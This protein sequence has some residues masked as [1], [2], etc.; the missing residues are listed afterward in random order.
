[1]GEEKEKSFKNK[2]ELINAAITEF[3]EKGYEQA[4]LNN[5]LKEA[6][7]SKGTFYYHFKHK[8]EL[9]FYLVDIFIAEKKIFFTENIDPKKYQKNIFDSLKF[10]AQKGVAFAQEHPQINQFAQSFI[11]ERGNQIYEKGLQKYDYQKDYFLDYLIE[12]AF[13]KGE[14]RKDLPVEFVKKLI[15]Y[16]FIHLVEI[17]EIVKIDDFNE[18]VYNL[19]EFIK[20]GLAKK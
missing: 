17:A 5:I 14:V 2:Q 12:K 8:E 19:I 13:L 3:S 18:A 16:L 10:L 11:K 7:I 20:D 4:S 9:Y 6:G 15:I 1:M